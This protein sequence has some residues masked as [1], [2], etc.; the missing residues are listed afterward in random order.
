[1]DVL[2]L[3]EELVEL[4]PDIVKVRLGSCGVWRWVCGLPMRERRCSMWRR[5]ILFGSS[6]TLVCVW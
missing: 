1:V 6:K 3:R 4:N 2:V 5:V